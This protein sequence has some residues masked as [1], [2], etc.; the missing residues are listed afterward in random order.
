LLLEEKKKL[1]LEIGNL[2]EQIISQVLHK[3]KRSSDWY[4]SDK[5][6]TCNDLSYEVKTLRL[7]NKTKSFWIDESQW[8]KLDSVDMVFFIKI[9]ESEDEYLKIYLCINHK[10][11]WKKEYKNNGDI[12]RSYPLTSCI[13]YGIIDDNRSKTIYNNSVAISKYGRYNSDIT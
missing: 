2:G 3:S 4:D 9:P 5:D 7:I 13:L 10:S 8:K 1:R 12:V 11:C 6:G